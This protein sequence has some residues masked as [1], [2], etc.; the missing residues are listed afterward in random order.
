[1]EKKRE[2]FSSSRVSPKLSTPSPQTAEADRSGI[3]EKQTVHAL[4]LAIKYSVKV[5]KLQG[6]DG[7]DPVNSLRP[8]NCQGGV[9]Q[10]RTAPAADQSCVVRGQRD[11]FRIWAQ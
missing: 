6:S 3:R 10:G 4:K 11:R 7:R 5:E 9:S 8:I 1:M 2:R